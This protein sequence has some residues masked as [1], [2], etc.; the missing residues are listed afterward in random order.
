ME[1]ECQ[2]VDGE[3]R[4]RIHRLQERC[5]GRPD[6]HFADFSA[7]ITDHPSPGTTTRIHLYD[8]ARHQC[9]SP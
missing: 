6:P 8:G 7:R 9:F 3:E 1:L 2:C 5:S 4:E